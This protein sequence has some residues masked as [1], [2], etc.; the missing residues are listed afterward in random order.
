MVGCGIRH[1]P[2]FSHS[3]TSS[4]STL[5]RYACIS[6]FFTT[7]ARSSAGE[8]EVEHHILKG[9]V[10]MK[11]KKHEKKAKRYM[12]NIIMYYKGVNTPL[13]IPW[14]RIADAGDRFIF[15]VKFLPG[16]IESKIRT[17]L[18]DVR[19]ALQ[20]HLFQ[21]HREGAD[22]FF[23]ATKDIDAGEN[24]LLRI[25]SDP[26]CRELVEGMSLP[27]AVGIDAIGCPLIVDLA[28]LT[29]LLIGGASNSGKTVGL[30]SLITSIVCTRLPEDVNLI[31]FDGASSL[32]QFDGLPHLSCPVIQDSETGFNAVMA[33]KDEMERRILLKSTDDFDNLPSIVLVVDEFISFITGIG[34][35]QRAN[36]LP[37]AISQMLRRGRHAKIH[38]VLAAQDPVI[39]E[40]KSDIGNITSRIAFTCAKANY[41]M[42]I[43]GEPGAEKL[44]NNGEMYFKSPK[45]SGLKFLK[46]SY[47]SSEELDVVLQRVMERDASYESE[48]LFRIDEADLCY[49]EENADYNFTGIPEATKVT[50][51]EKL[52]AHIIMWSLGRES[53]S[54]NAIC[55]AFSIGWRRADKALMAMSQMK[56]VGDGYAKLAREVI[57]THYEA[58]PLDAISL[59]ERCGYTEEDIRNA[60][61]PRRKNDTA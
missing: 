37:E 25:M 45:H 60:F 1:A 38:V 24:R 29:H 21:L 28:E 26:S 58:M 15:K 42:T 5:R 36:Q 3:Y 6:R 30:K 32:E 18:S 22:L 47:I 54:R 40:M 8:E 41:S 57:P 16:T 31:I 9:F 19:Q 13:D 4:A 55:T 52:L 56:L 43:L 17:Y 35:A 50:A 23:V 39:K 12:R 51:D 27:Y 48:H 14:C 46:G 33:L 61:S 2:K 11:R 10:S 44:L 59:L 34:D 49:T 53:I 7:L 20:L